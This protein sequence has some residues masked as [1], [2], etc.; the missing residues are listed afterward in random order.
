MYS[1]LW[2][3]DEIPVTPLPAPA[4]IPVVRKKRSSG[5]VLKARPDNV[6]GCAPEHIQHQL[7]LWLLN[8]RTSYDEVVIKLA[9]RYQLH[10]NICAISKYYRKIVHPIIVKRRA[11]AVELA[12]LMAKHISKKPAKFYL[13]AMDELARRG[14][15]LAIDE[16]TSAKELTRMIDSMIRARKQT[17][18]EQKLVLMERRLKVVERRQEALEEA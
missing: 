9:E 18:D 3:M 13:T 4:R 2:A 12:D 10:T 15:K 1:S 11:E 16:N 14:M 6:L 8:Q 7:I 17:L 5:I